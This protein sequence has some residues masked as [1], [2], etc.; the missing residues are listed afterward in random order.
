MNFN[1]IAILCTLTAVGIAGCASDPGKKVDTAENALTSD[2]QKAHTEEA[3]KNA[4]ATRKHEGEH[5][6]S[7]ADKATTT[8][9]AKKDVSVA[10]ANLADDRRDFDAK[11][12]ERLAKIDAKAKELKTK[13]AKLTGKK[14]TDFKTRNATFTTQRAEANTKV[15]GLATSTNDGW[16]TAKADVEKKLESLETTL[17]T[18]DKDL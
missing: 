17:D 5:A 6:E 12:K 11:T 18:M 15:S 16:S 8:S 10:H 7:A 3:D 14:A 9:E 1:R 2:Q 13:S 4:E